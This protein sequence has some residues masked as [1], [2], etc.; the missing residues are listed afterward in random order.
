MRCFLFE[1][2]AHSLTHCPT[3]PD[4]DSHGLSPLG[5]GLT[6]R[7]EHPPSP[8]SSSHPWSSSSKFEICCPHP[9]RP[10]ASSPAP[11]GGGSHGDIPTVQRMGIFDNFYCIH[12]PPRF[13]LPGYIIASTVLLAAIVTPTPSHAHAR[14]PAAL[15][16]PARLSP[17]CHLPFLLTTPA[18]AGH[19]KNF[20][21]LEL[22][23]FGQSL[24]RATY[25]YPDTADTFTEGKCGE[26]RT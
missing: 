26:E 12:S 9:A 16:S 15:V 1:W 24:P 20:V 23:P 7:G 8:V 3:S 6:G 10:S 17:E 19:S 11:G 4:T 18:P 13:C 22:L 21:L 25:K 5:E 2:C 14:P